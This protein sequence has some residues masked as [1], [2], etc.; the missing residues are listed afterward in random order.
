MEELEPGIRRITLELPVRPGHVHAYLLDDATLVDTGLGVPDAAE[1]WRAH[2][3]DARVERVVVTHFH[4]DHVGAARD[5]CLLTNAPVHQG[6]VDY[7]Q[8]VHVW[9]NPEWPRQL[10][11][12]FERAGV[13]PEL[14]EDLV[15]QG[16]LYRP[17]VRFVRDPH[18]LYEGDVVDGWRVLETPGHADGHVALLRDGVLVSADF[19]LDPITPAVGWWPDSRPD[20]LGDYLRALARV[21]ELAPRVAYPGHG[22]PITDPVGRARELIAFHAQ[23][24]DET[25]AALGPEPRSGYEVSLEVFGRRLRPAARRFAV[26]ETLSHLER[27]VHEGR[28]ARADG[29]GSTKPQ[30]SAG[31]GL[32]GAGAGNGRA[33][34]YTAP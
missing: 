8:C 10:V 20:P 31:A 4:P 26:A 27:L 24:L 30:G 21:Q 25:E 17:F 28:A 14:T 5:V 19:L 18:L 1:T 7:A 29:V 15:E 34:A 11:D 32:A 2:L 23:R 22:E 13:P 3:G 16:S 6:A 12:W 9:D 33:H